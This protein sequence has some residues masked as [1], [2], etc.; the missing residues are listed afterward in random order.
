MKLRT[1]L[2]LLGSLAVLSASGGL[3]AA[4][5]LQQEARGDDPVLSIASAAGAEESGSC[6]QEDLPP[7][8][9]QE[10]IGAVGNS[11]NEAYPWPATGSGA[12]VIE[13]ED[14]LRSI[15]RFDVYFP[16]TPPGWTRETLL[17][18]QSARR[19]PLHSCLISV[20]LRDPSVTQT[21]VVPE[22]KE[23]IVNEQGNEVTLGGYTDVLV[24]EARITVYPATPLVIEVPDGEGRANEWI[25]VNGNRALLVTRAGSE[26]SVGVGFLLGT[27]RVSLDCT[28]IPVDECLAIAATI[29]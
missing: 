16:A 10:I 20:T 17:V 2:L 7:L 29:R 13:D 25:D 24:K 5:L 28:L 12:V 9:R 27:S 6:L 23:P 15:V 1:R 22:D 19:T 11:P 18:S 4:V 8:Q 14:A 26:P 3:A 21:L